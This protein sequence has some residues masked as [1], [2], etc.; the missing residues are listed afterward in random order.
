VFCDSTGSA[1][2]PTRRVTGMDSF[3]P[4]FL[5]MTRFVDKTFKAVPTPILFSDRRK[6][7]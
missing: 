4:G 7:A 6:T 5:D 2:N 1:D 3:K